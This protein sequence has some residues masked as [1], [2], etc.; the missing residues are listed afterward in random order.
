MITVAKIICRDSQVNRY[1]EENTLSAKI[2]ELD[3]FI[4]YAWLA[5]AKPGLR[6][7]SHSVDMNLTHVWNAE[8]LERTKNLNQA[9]PQNTQTAP[10]TKQTTTHEHTPA[11]RN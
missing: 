2:C 7:Q 5:K 4:Q 6:K 1:A 11:D 10:Q 8:E 9:Q 3:E